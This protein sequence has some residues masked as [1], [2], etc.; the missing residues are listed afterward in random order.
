MDP[1]LE[2]QAEAPPDLV[3]LEEEEDELFDMQVDSDELVDFTYDEPEEFDEPSVDIGS[4]IAGS[5]P[6]PSLF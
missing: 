5:E 6:Q 4:A 3:I 2:G 1:T